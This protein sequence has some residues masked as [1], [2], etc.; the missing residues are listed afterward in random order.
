MGQIFPQR[1]GEKSDVQKH[2][3]PRGVKEGKAG[4]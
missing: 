2:V 3:P 1:K 4:T